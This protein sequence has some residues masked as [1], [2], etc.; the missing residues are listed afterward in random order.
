[1]ATTQKSGIFSFF[2]NGSK[3]TTAEL[4]AKVDAIGKSQGV[5][6]FNLDGTVITANDNFLNVLGYTLNEAVGVHHRNFVE[7][8]YGNSS[9]YRKF[10]EKLNRGEF[11]SGEY[12]RIAKGGREVYIQASYNPMFGSNGKPYKIV[13]FATEITEQVLK[14]ADFE[15][16][17]DAIE[18]S[19]G[20]I[21][22]KGISKNRIKS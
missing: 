4:Q 16:K 2:S 14:N 8:S 18:K 13:K 10:W 5:I 22:F 21:E 3:D 20:V 11:D 15:G 6:E 7:P 9:E 12:K 19:Q 17:V 1:M